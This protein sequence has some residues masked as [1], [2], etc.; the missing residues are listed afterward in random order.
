LAAWTTQLRFEDC[1]DQPPRSKIST[2]R[3]LNGRTLGTRGA[4]RCYRL[5]MATQ[6]QRETLAAEIAAFDGMREELL[7]H[8]AG[9]FALIKDGQLAGT[10][11]TEGE[12]Y[13]DGVAKFDGG[14]FLVRQ[15]A[16][17]AQVAMMPAL[18]AGLI[19]API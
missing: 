5:Y 12:A 10:F 7:K 16:Q 14:V 1:R 13:A 6:E 11:T 3:S 2:S 9:K 15:I 4:A 19:H 8:H 17:D 18:F